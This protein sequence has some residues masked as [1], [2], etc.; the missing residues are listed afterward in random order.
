MAK[1]LIAD[2]SPTERRMMADAL[3]KA[4][5]ETIEA[6]DGPEVE[7][8]MDEDTPDLLILDVVM[9][10]KDGYQ[11]CRTIKSDDRYRVIPIIMISA[12]KEESDRY[13]GLKQGADKY[14]AKPFSMEKLVRAVESF[15]LKQSGS[16]A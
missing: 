3:Q 5:F 15:L 13:W 7:R 1:I 6:G 16:E 4:G 12:R 11:L 9:P 8:L 10:G 14:I 2:D